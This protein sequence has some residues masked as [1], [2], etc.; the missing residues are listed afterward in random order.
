M[1]ERDVPAPPPPPRWLSL[2]ELAPFTDRCHFCNCLWLLKRD[3]L[4]SIGRA[5]L[6]ISDLVCIDSSTL[7]FNLAVRPGSAVEKTCLLPVV[8]VTTA[9]KLSLHATVCRRFI[10]NN[11]HIGTDLTTYHAEMGRTF[12]DTYYW[13]I[14]AVN[15]I[16]FYLFN[17]LIEGCLMN[18]HLRGMVEKHHSQ[19]SHENKYFCIE[20]GRMF[21]LRVQQ[22]RLLN[23]CANSYYEQ[24]KYWISESDAFTKEVMT[25]MLYKPSKSKTQAQKHNIMVASARCTLLLLLFSGL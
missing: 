16:L 21:M 18:T 13:Q 2:R 25:W 10:D 3:Y 7:L 5:P 4:Q 6:R 17:A 14:T 11:Q 23:G 9:T 1:S 8:R 22:A 24:D 12:M 15:S 19:R 20:Y